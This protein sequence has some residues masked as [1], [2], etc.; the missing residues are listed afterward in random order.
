MKTILKTNL[1][2]KPYK[3]L[4]NPI[5]NDVLYRAG[6]EFDPLSVE[7]IYITSL[8]K[9]MLENRSHTWFIVSYYPEFVLREI[10]SQCQHLAHYA[11]CTHNNDLD[12]KNN[13]KKDHTH[14]LLCFDFAE[15]ASRVA[16]FFHTTQLRAVSSHDL[17][18][19]FNYLIHDS[20]ACRKEGKYLYDNS[21]RICD[22]EAYFLSRCCKEN[23]NDT[24]V[25]MITDFTKLTH[26]QMVSKYGWKFI[27]MYKNIREITNAYERES[28]SKSVD[29]STGEI[30]VSGKGKDRK[31]LGFQVV[32]DDINKEF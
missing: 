11:F 18:K 8:Q 6:V 13:H 25:S 30:I 7:D 22:D 15:Y 12:E 2:D 4:S 3:I 5:A 16:F 23:E 21:A 32:S 17:S 14:L 1:D 24:Y 28:N 19:E 29:L 31:Y 26:I 10:L 27:S 9:R 20:D